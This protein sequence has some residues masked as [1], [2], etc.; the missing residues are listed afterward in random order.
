M[1][2]KQVL[3]YL[4]GCGI[5]FFFP[6][7]TGS[8][9]VRAN[10]GWFFINKMIQGDLA[11][12]GTHVILKLACRKKDCSGVCLR[13]CDM[14]IVQDMEVPGMDFSAPNTGVGLFSKIP[15][16]KLKLSLRKDQWGPGFRANYLSTGN[17]VLEESFTLPAALYT[18]LGFS[19]AFTILEGSY[20]VLELED[21]FII[22]F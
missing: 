15:G 1:K 16:N 17:F 19:E 12:D 3:W 20:P 13:I 6:L 9:S 5:L 7:Q 14:V 10:P 18:N 22:E 4:T 2:M 8:A 21:R 11:T